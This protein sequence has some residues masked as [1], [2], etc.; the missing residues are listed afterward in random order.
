MS[1]VAVL[2][3]GGILGQPMAR[4]IAAAGMEVRAWNRT[5]EKAEPLGEHGVTVVDTAAEAAEGADVLVTILAEADAVA[6]AMTDVRGPAV[7]AQMSTVGLDG[8]DRCAALARERD[9]QLVDA[10]VLGTKA[11]AEAGE[12]IVLASGPQAARGAVEPVFDAVGKLTRWVGEEPGA[13]TRL[14]V[15]INAWIVGVM[16]TTAETLALAEGLGVDPQEVLDTLAGG[17][18]DLP[19]LQAKGKMIIERDFPPSFKLSLAAKDARLM[20]EAAEAH[21]LDL[22]L[23]R[24]IRDRM[25]EGAEEHGEEDMAATYW[26]SAPPA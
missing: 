14:K 15:A 12:L 22:P 16:E 10:P 9:M 4:N 20:V 8:A 1:T 6:E 23:L 24:T 19:Y 21:G 17:P 26:A 11:P 25:A 18:L 3:A 5:R 13:G 2:G 7:W